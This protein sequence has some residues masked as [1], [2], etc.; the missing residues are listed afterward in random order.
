MKKIIMILAIVAALALSACG[1]SSQDPPEVVR[2]Y[3][4]NAYLVVKDKQT[5]EAECESIRA[6]WNLE[7]Q[8]VY[9]ED[10]D[11]NDLLTCER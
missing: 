6:N 10:E 3:N 4:G 11:G 8:A 5:A 7:D 2:S 9:F 1:T